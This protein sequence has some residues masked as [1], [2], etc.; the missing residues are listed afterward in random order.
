MEV[1]RRCWIVARAQRTCQL[2]R[3][4]APSPMESGPTGSWIRSS[5][6]DR[7]CSNPHSCILAGR[8]AHPLVPPRAAALDSPGS[9]AGDRRRPA[10]SN[11]PELDVAVP[12]AEVP[13]AFT[14]RPATAR[15]SGLSLIGTLLRFPVVPPPA[16]RLRR[17]RIR[18]YIAA[19]LLL[20]AYPPVPS[21]FRRGPSLEKNGKRDARRKCDADHTAD[22]DKKHHRRS[23]PA[24]K[25]ARVIR[26]SF[27]QTIAINCQSPPGRASLA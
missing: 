15:S 19:K 9:V 10:A 8:I 22:H 27:P 24:G 21:Q 16:R 5:S 25:C 11:N 4:P 3:R 14:T 7:S 18:R 13:S 26:L 1:R 6:Q 2:G 12:R 20:E 17:T 23:A